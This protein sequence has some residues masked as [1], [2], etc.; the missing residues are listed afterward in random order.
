MLTRCAG[1]HLALI[2]FPPNLF[3]TAWFDDNVAQVSIGYKVPLLLQVWIKVADVWTL[4]LYRCTLV[5]IGAT[6]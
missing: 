1:G 3:V 5:L 4:M 2:T 6:S